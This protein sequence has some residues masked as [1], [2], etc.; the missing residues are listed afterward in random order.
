MASLSSSEIRHNIKFN[1]LNGIFAVMGMNLVTPFISVWAMG[2]G[3]TNFQIGLISSLPPLI[4]LVAMLP[5]AFFVDRFASKRNITGAFIFFQR[6]FFV[7]LALTPFLPAHYV[8]Y[9]VIING[10][11]NFPGSIANVA[12]Q[13]F[14]A[15]AIPA[16]ERAQAFAQR[17][18][19]SSLCGLAVTFLAGQIFRVVPAARLNTMYMI[20]FLV[21]FGFALVEVWSHMQMREIVSAPKEEA[22][23]GVLPTFKAIF[24]Q[25][26]FIVFCLCSLVFHFGWQMA[27][28]LFSIYKVRF[29]G[30]NETWVSLINVINGLG[31]FISYG[32]WRRIIEKRGNHSVL[33]VAAMGISTA[34]FLYSISSSLY[35]LALANVLLG[36]AVAGINLTLFN[37]LLDAVPEQNRTIY[38]AAYTM[39]INTSAV[40]AP[41]VGIAILDRWNIVTALMVAGGLR[42]LGTCTFF[43]RGKKISRVPGQEAAA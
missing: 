31:S 32:F 41:M 18:R 39:L 28:P 2:M 33:A 24:S 26:A 19:L 38:I 22:K 14:I 29:L 34:P 23:L 42:L 8:W 20:F 35:Q 37:S 1:T 25:R 40:M 13:S 9:L 11:M 5:G 15:G 12:W 43:L 3:G 6:L 36:I 30:A 10:L 17:N 16:Q 27:W 4:G 21:A 7:L